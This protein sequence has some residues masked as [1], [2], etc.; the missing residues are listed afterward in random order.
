MFVDN[1]SIKNVRELIQDFK[2]YLQLQKEY[3]QL[4]ITEKVT[5]I[6]SSILLITIMAIL[7]MIVLFYLSLA[8]V[9]LLAPY[10]GG[11][12]VSFTITAGIVLL[13]MLMAYVFR[14]HLIITP[15][16]NFLANIFAKKP[17]DE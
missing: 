8:F 17:K 3:T 11:L 16:V 5:T 6:I 12:I 2:K 15:L 10:V 14:Q 1:D 4:E 9:Y 7:G 13:V